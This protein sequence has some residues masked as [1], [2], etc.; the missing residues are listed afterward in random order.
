MW[1]Y[2]NLIFKVFLASFESSKNFLPVVTL[3]FLW[4]DIYMLDITTIHNLERLTWTLNN[5]GKISSIIQHGWRVAANWPD[6]WKAIESILIRRVS[7]VKSSRR[8][9]DR[10]KNRVRNWRFNTVGQFSPCLL[11]V[12]VIVIFNSSTKGCWEISRFIF[13]LKQNIWCM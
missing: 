13:L 3:F 6:W 10:A 11:D 1:K 9:Y 5:Y 12:I 4:Y 8:F 7:R 2:I